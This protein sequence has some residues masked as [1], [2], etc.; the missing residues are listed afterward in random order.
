MSE[1]QSRAEVEEVATVIAAGYARPRSL[2]HIS[3]PL[4]SSQIAI[5]ANFF[6]RYPD[7]PVEVA[8]KDQ[9]VDPFEEG[10][11]H[12]IRVNPPADQ[13]L[14]GRCFLQDRLVVVAAP[15]ISHPSSHHACP[16]GLLRTAYMM[17]SR[18]RDGGAVRR[19]QQRNHR[20]HLDADQ[21]RRRE[22][23]WSQCGLHRPLRSPFLVLQRY[24][25]QAV[26]VS[27]RLYVHRER[28]R[29][30]PRYMYGGFIV[31]AA[32]QQLPGT[33]KWT[34]KPVATG[35]VGPYEVQGIGDFVGRRFSTFANDACPPTS[36]FQTASSHARTPPPRF[37]RWSFCST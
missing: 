5:G 7:R 30:R 24:L 29:R 17:P 11:D 21:R 6:G 9:N 27:E 15:S 32:G 13:S 18:F 10:Y 26:E 14:I 28:H 1:C 8:A 31:P 3:A 34:N 35:S 4:L 25:V 36:S 2:L 37:A 23:R 12:V 16:C 22:D 33:S 19:R 20:R